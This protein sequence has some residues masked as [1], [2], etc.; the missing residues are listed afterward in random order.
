MTTKE[1]KRIARILKEVYKK[2]EEEAL[3]NG[4]N[5]LSS[6]Y[7]KLIELARVRVLEEAGYTLE[8]YREA[9]AK[10]AGYSQSDYLESE[11]ETKEEFLKILQRIEDLE[12]RY[13][14]NDEDIEKISERVSKKYIKEPQ[15][16]NKI[17]DRVTIKE[18]KIVKETIKVKE[19]VDYDDKELKKLI[20]KLDDRITT[21]K[22]FVLKELRTFND[23]FGNNLKKNIDMFGMPD[24]RKLAMGLD[25]RIAALEGGGG[26]GG[27]IDGSGTTNELVYWV[28]SD[29]IGSL[30]TATYP[31]LT[32][33]SYSKGV[34]SAIQTQLN[35][36][37]GLDT[38]LT[39]LA[40]LSYTGN[41]L[42]VIR[43]NAGETD[44]ELATVS[45]LSDGDKGD[46]TVSASGA[47]WTI[48]ND[49]V[50]YAKMQNVSAT[51]KILG[52]V[53]AGAG[54]VEEITFTDFAQSLADDVDAATARTTLG[55]V[56]GTNVQAW[57]AQLDTWATV[58][59]SANGQSLVS[60]ANYAAMRG[61][62]DLEAGTDFYSIAGADAAF[63]Q[64]DADLTTLSTA[65]TSASASGA[66]SLQFHEDTDNG[67]NKITLT[68]PDSI[69]SDKVIAMPDV[70]GT[71]ALLDNTGL[72]DVTVDTLITNTGTISSSS[73]TFSNTG[74]DLFNFEGAS[75]GF[76]AILDVS[77]LTSADRTFSFP[78][79]TGTFALTS[80]I[81]SLT[82]YVNTS[83]TPANNQLAIFT[84]AD[85]VEGDSNL[86]WDGTNFN[87]ATA[88]NFQI[89]GATI[90]SDSTGTTTLQNIDALDATTEATIEAAIDTLANLTS[91]QGRTVTLADAGA[92]AV[93]GWDDV[94]GAYEN[95]TAS[96]V[97][98]AIGL[99]T[100]DSPEFTALNIGHAS[101]TTL[102]RVSAGVI[103]VEGKTV[104]NLTD[105]G[106]F[107]ADISVPD[108]A[109]G[110]GWNGSVEVPTKNAIYDKIETLGTGSTEAVTKSISQ[111]THGFAVGD[112]LKYASS[113]YAKAQADSASNAE[114]VGI[115]S[116][117]ADANTFTLLTHGYISTLSGLTANTTY[118]LSAS[119]AGALTS[120][121]PSTVGQIS[122]P[123]L[124]AVS[125]TAGY[126]M[127]MRGA[128]VTSSTSSSMA[129]VNGGTASANNITISSLDLNTDTKYVIHFKWRASSNATG[130]D[131]NAT[132]S[133][134]ASGNYGYALHGW[135]YDSSGSAVELQNTGAA[136]D[137]WKIC[138]EYDNG[139]GTLTISKV[140]D[141]SNDYFLAHWE[142]MVSANNA[143]GSP[144]REVMTI[145]GAGNLT[146]TSTA[147]MTSFTLDWSNGAS[148][149]A[150]DVRVYKLINS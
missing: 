23:N 128:A 70:A 89:A 78:D 69:A 86:T 125:T 11:E 60:A 113:T 148:S 99:A 130:S 20:G 17:V 95:L 6:D 66:A 18:P 73:F 64:K 136:N 110:A 10:V 13:V 33:L 63:Q 100:T 4:I 118:F 29:T 3:A 53:T 7:D 55:L 61:L 109:Y 143:D 98:G 38:Q 46:I 87:I 35:N 62:L 15:I 93:F 85:T 50:T 24:F 57:D 41:A 79:A 135:G 12:S 82:G 91:I 40:A 65:F 104:V 103:A 30:S 43:V 92:N 147:N 115:V 39:S 83:G 94:A 75:S 139:F 101:D 58:T 124:R 122:K 76:D 144:A 8:E 81:P 133:A 132:I 119:S 108:E 107:L 150:F 146:A 123:V 47:T 22:E 121:E 84:D 142:V 5:I 80:D 137:F 134:G 44:F 9:K 51:D 34:T 140:T 127:N 145:N 71:M 26:G 28:D 126:F 112:V 56:I 42:K 141:G 67:T 25:A 52:R 36:K 116:A 117:V 21:E 31:S 88:K 54:D 49:V 2:V 111:T 114:V 129:Y 90:L 19:R 131:L 77:N 72:G 32:E 45:A 59:P 105:G 102:S 74:T 27:T 96:E 1:F 106:T 149:A 120:T 16:I 97:R 48:D 138:D 37:Q 14:P 68:A